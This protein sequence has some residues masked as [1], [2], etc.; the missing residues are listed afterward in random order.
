MAR[1]GVDPRRQLNGYLNVKRQSTEAAFRSAL[2]Q[3]QSSIS[4]ETL[5]D[6]IEQRTTQVPLFQ[7]MIS[8]VWE[9]FI[10]DEL[11]TT[12]LAAAESGAGSIDRAMI[13]EPSRELGALD[14]GIRPV[15]RER[16]IIVLK[17]EFPA[18]ES[19]LAFLVQHEDFL[20]RHFGQQAGRSLVEVLQVAARNGQWGAGTVARDLRG[21]IALTP[22]DAARLARR[23][24][25][26][27]QSG[28]S[29]AKARTNLKAAEKILIERRIATIAQHEVAQMWNIGALESVKDRVRFGEIEPQ[30]LKVWLTTEDDLV[31]PI[32]APLNNKELSLDADFSSQGFIGQSPPAHIRC[33]CALA[34]IRKVRF[35]GK[36]FTLDSSP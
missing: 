33:R 17:Q 6:L 19:V 2:G 36:F 7:D 18:E 14:V 8:R 5:G 16:S 20:L 21:L 31:C 12:L 10:A 11:H 3:V 30:A 32:C 28:V 34:Y 25:I 29:A 4:L 15:I 35:L 22:R 26:D 23:Y 13:L 9:G 1:K 24:E 27:R